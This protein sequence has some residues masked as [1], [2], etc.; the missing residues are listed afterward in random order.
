VDL[1]GYGPDQPLRPADAL[2][3]FLRALE[4]NGATI[5]PDLAER[6]AR[7][8][9]LV[10]QQRQLLVLDNAAT[11]DQVRP[12]LPGTSTC[13]V[14][15]TSRNALAGL[16]ARDGARRITL[17]RMTAA[18]AHALL[19]EL[20]GDPGDAE[21]EERNRLIERCA[22]LPLALR[23]A[24][25]QIEQQSGGDISTLATELAS[26]QERL[27]L[28]D[29]GDDHTSVR[30]VLSW[31]YRHLTPAA[32]RMFRLLGV[33]PG[34]DVDLYA[35][36]ALTGTGDERR[37]RRQ[38]EQ[39]VR[40]HLV[41]SGSPGRYHQHDL[42][43][44]YASELADGDPDEGAAMRRLLDYYVH[45]AA[46]A[47]DLVAP[48]DMELRSLPVPRPGI[49]PPLSSTEDALRWLDTERANL[50]RVAER[51]TRFGLSRYTTDLSAVLWRYL[52]VG[53]HLSDAW[54]LHDSALV[55]ARKTGD[56]AAEGISLRAL[57]L[58]SFRMDRYQEA[59]THL[60]RAFTCHAGIADDPL[61]IT[62]LNYLGIACHRAGRTEDSIRHLQQAIYLSSNNHRSLRAKPLNNLGFV[63]LRRGQF[64]EAFQCLTRALGAAEEIGNRP[65]QAH[66]HSYLA[67]LCRD[68]GRYDD[69]LGHANRAVEIAHEVGMLGPEGTALHHLGTVHSRLGNYDTAMR[70]HR[71]A[72]AKARLTHDN[73]DTAL[74]LNGLAETC[75]MTGAWADAQRHYNEA[76][77]NA[78]GNSVRY[79]QARAFA[80]LGYVAEH[81]GDR[82]AATRLWRQ[83][84]DIYAELGAR[85]ADIVRAKLLPA[86]VGGAQRPRGAT[87]G[88]RWPGQQQRARYPEPVDQQ[89]TGVS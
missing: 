25:E 10:D 69:A 54:R 63:Y 81:Q 16:A 8:R 29:A 1:H 42:L 64:D 68:A 27:D 4:P 36:S 78:T 12:L 38:L 44:A 82:P 32:A 71:Q 14:L 37:T 26:E 18:E 86:V 75:A 43:R 50:I 67:W 5:P 22:R 83:A 62:T 66:A 84:F 56:L 72:L 30:A 7:F 45:T 34:H 20:L 88:P 35:L 39:L 48:Q 59:V 87:P 76:L 28:L 53:L 57:G 3:G 58:A 31:S 15:I 23:I 80:G 9:T 77:A 55:A 49:V 61:R 33:H 19:A 47:M 46:M 65:S 51:A 11:V 21:H 89:T 60:E 41:D 2:A 74:A 24:A 52:D 13:T 85:E 17:D 40:T 79:E 70:Y 6:A 73:H